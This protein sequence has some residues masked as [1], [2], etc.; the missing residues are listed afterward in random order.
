MPGP[1]R[2]RLRRLGVLGQ[3]AEG[4]P[5]T[6]AAAPVRP[7]V[8]LR[9]VDEA[10]APAQVAKVG[11]IRPRLAVAARPTTKATVGV[12]VVHVPLLGKQAKAVRTT[13]ARP[14]P[15]LPTAT[16]PALGPL[17]AAAQ[18]VS[19]APTEVAVVTRA[20]AIPPTGP[21]HGPTT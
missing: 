14:T 17:V 11:P 19:R 13:K 18:P 4:G 12:D 10:K 9:L 6:I 15:V 16:C 7:A 2:R 8:E 21:C 5:S 1:N 3:G 20:H